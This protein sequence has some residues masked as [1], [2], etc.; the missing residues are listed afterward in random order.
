MKKEKKNAK[1]LFLFFLFFFFLSDKSFAAPLLN[2]ENQKKSIP[3]FPS[4]PH[5]TRNSNEIDINNFTRL[6]D[7]VSQTK[8][9]I[10]NLY[11]KL[12]KYS[13][14][15]LPCGSKWPLYDLNTGYAWGPSGKGIFFTNTCNSTWKNFP[16]WATPQLD[17]GVGDNNPVMTNINGSLFLS[18]QGTSSS[19]PN[20]LLHVQAKNWL[21]NAPQW[22]G[23]V[24]ADTPTAIFSAEN[25][26][27][28]LDEKSFSRGSP[29][30]LHAVTYN[31]SNQNW[32]IQAQALKETCYNYKKSGSCWANS[33]ELYDV[34]GFSPTNKF[35]QTNEN[36][37]SGNGSELEGAFFNPSLSARIMDYAHG[38]A[39][40]PTNWQPLHFY[41]KNDVTLVNNARILIALSS[42]KS[43][44]LPPENFTRENEIIKDG[45]LSWKIGAK[46]DNVVGVVHWIN[47]DNG[48]G[49][50]HNSYNFGYS[51]N[52]K[53]NN[54]VFDASHAHAND[55]RFVA[56]RIGS[57]QGIDVSASPE[58]KSDNDINRNIWKY[59]SSEKSFEYFVNGVKMI[60]FQ[61]DG[62]A[63]FSGALTPA[64]KT[65]ASI[66]AI[67]PPRGSHPIYYD[68]TDDGPAIYTNKGWKLI[69]LKNIPTDN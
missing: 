34:S 7:N 44:F 45:Q 59:I 19:N 65:R 15:T 26:T 35:S 63:I 24:D 17:R 46:Y 33:S 9:Y 36:D 67:I 52:S 62:S 27:Y 49:S 58:A 50:Q 43:G 22:P 55:K 60:S 11:D 20:G 18:R 1:L 48:Q 5:N 13:I 41:K 16:S 21:T 56:L 54:S 57:D 28:S 40:T 61:D 39:N 6:N 14:V 3:A 8:E 51:T 68:T 53:F 30:A 38:M 32:S 25:S 42:G 12:P 69:A 37:L 23:G 2:I 10:E 64:A 29:L 31:Y 4:T 66:L 47:T